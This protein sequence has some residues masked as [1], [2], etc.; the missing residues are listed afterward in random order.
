MDHID[1]KRGNALFGSIFDVV[2]AAYGVNTQ[3]AFGN[4]GAKAF[5]QDFEAEAD[6]IGMYVLALADYQ[7]DDVANFWRRMGA[8][9]PGSI[10]TQYSGTHPG[11]AERYLA[12]EQIAEEIRIKREAGEELRPNYKKDRAEQEE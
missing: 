7:V 9:N 11:T 1:K 3:G 6:Y 8:S 4:M 12:L 10:E 2:A 5:S